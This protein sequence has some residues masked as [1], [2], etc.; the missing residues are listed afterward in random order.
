MSFYGNPYDLFQMC[1]ENGS[2]LPVDQQL[3]RSFEPRIFHGVPYFGC[4]RMHSCCMRSLTESLLGDISGKYCRFGIYLSALVSSASS[5]LVHDL[6]HWPRAASGIGTLRP[7]RYH[8]RVRVGVRRHHSGRILILHSITQYSS[9]SDWLGGLHRSK[10][11]TFAGF[12]VR[13]L[14]MESA[15]FRPMRVTARNHLSIRTISAGKRTSS[16]SL[17]GT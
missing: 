4:Y 10:G 6:R 9:K 3:L 5:G 12:C 7:L 8:L 11:E 14:F 1:H 13:K 16:K 2:S 17:R 15:H